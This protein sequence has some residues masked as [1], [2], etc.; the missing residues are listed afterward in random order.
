MVRHLIVG[1]M[2]VGC[3]DH[4]SATTD[5]APIDTAVSIDAPATAQ[6][7]SAPADTWTWVDFADSKCASGTATGIGINPH[8][9]AT[10]VVIYFEGGGACTDA[11]SCW[12]A[13][14][15]ANNLAGY[16][17]TTFE[18]AQQRKYPL[19]NRA[20]AGNPF[21]DKN[22]VYIP[23]CT[24]D[25]H[26]G[27]TDVDLGTMHTYFWG[28]KDLDLFLARLAPT[29]PTAQHIWSYGTSAGGFGSFLA[30]SHVTAAF[31]AARVDIVDDSGPAIVAN[32]ATDNHG[33]LTT[34]GFVAPSGCS[35]CTKLFDVLETDRAAQPASKY[36]FLSFAQDTVIA[37]D[38]LYSLA[39]YPGVMSSYSQGLSADTHAATYIFSNEQ[40]HVVESDL[41]NATKYLPW[42]TLMVTDDPSWADATNP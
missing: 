31:P 30:Y 32:G 16:D 42:I 26:G 40:G 1:T 11:D 12:G 5:G 6:P 22:L 17:A 39:A 25:M 29:F 23:Y 19:L 35:P 14:P 13:T 2:L 36:A 10:D 7:I 34:W 38:F 28:A 3:G 15:K 4:S 41:A 9:G 33:I 21:K 37:P 20:L 24:G 27:A 18:A 8:A